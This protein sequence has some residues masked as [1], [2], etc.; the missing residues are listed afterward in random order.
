MICRN[1]DENLKQ[2]KHDA[3]YTL[4]IKIITNSSDTLL[5]T[6]CKLL[7]AVMKKFRASGFDKLLEGSFN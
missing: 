1:L 7:Y 6:R 4:L 2:L 5:L 3:I